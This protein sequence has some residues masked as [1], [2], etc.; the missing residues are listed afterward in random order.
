MKKLFCFILAAAMLLCIPVSA[1]AEN[2]PSLS[3][4]DDGKFVILNISDPQDDHHTA[5]DLINFVTLAIEETKPDLVVISGDIV[6]DNRAGDLGV[7]GEGSRE[8]VTVN[9]NGELDYAATLK[10]VKTACDNIFSI[11]NDAK[12]PFTVAQGNNDYQSGITNEDWLKI[13]SY[14]E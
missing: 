7:D 12:I 11:I 13:Y 9:K 2:E 10:N 8:G 4:G 5:Y 14:S 1:N 6:E 3:F